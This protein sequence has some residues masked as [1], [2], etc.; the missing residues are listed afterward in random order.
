MCQTLCSGLRFMAD[1]MYRYLFRG[2]LFAYILVCIFSLYSYQMYLDTWIV[3]E[4]LARNC[5]AL[6]GRNLKNINLNLWL[7]LTY[8]K[9]WT[10]QG[11]CSE[12]TLPLG[13]QVPLVFQRNPSS[14]CAIAKHGS[15]GPKVTKQLPFIQ[16]FIQI[17]NWKKVKDKMQKESPCNSDPKSKLSPNL[18][19]FPVM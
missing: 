10:L 16:V 1:H 13:T 15:I 2:S 9:V 11:W 8:I 18:R 4:C 17:L 7:Y 19:I 3:K 14:F 12:S 5:L 6:S